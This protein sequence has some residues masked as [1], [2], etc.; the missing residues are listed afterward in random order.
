[1][2]EIGGMTKPIRRSVLVVGVLLALLAPAGAR[3]H[4]GLRTSTPAAGDS[5]GAA[6]S[7]ISLV[8]TREVALALVSASLEGPA[9]AVALGEPVAGAGAEVTLTVRGSMVAGAYTLR[10]RIVGRD[11][12]PVTGTIEFAVRDGAAGVAQPAAAAEPTEAEPAPAGMDDHEPPADIDPFG[13]ESAGYVLVRWVGYLA[14]VGVLGVIAFGLVVLPLARARGVMGETVASLA[15]EAGRL[16]LPAAVL[17]LVATAARLIA[18]SAAVH[19]PDATFEPGGIAGILGSTVWG[20]GWL[21]QLA[22]AALAL[23]AFVLAGRGRR[24]GWTL[25]ALAALALTIAPPLSGHAAAVEPLGTL[26]IAADAL[27]VLGAGGWIGALFVV[28][29]LA[30]VRGNDALRGGALASLVAAFSGAA[31]GFAALLVV[32]GV[33]TTWIHLPSLAD[34]WR[35]DYG[36]T[37]LLKS[38]ALLPLFATGAYNWKRVRPAL[39]T[40]ADPSALRRSAALELGVAVLVLLITAVLVATPPPE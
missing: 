15:A 16:G 29:V 37:L 39:D 36:R 23:V 2:D 40:G 8:F 17:L 3:A 35:S 27:H 11:G 30:V 19:G 7:A 25:A 9:G 5:L 10:W 13:P 20:T 28:F 18:Q 32:S 22:G 6:P 14:L 24:A 33:V 26:A 21:I 12:H 38:G 34:L 1:M 4:D 31:L